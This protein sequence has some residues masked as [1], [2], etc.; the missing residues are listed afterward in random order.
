MV[1]PYAN[2]YH[3]MVVALHYSGNLDPLDV[4][5][6]Q[7]SAVFELRPRNTSLLIET[8]SQ[9]T[10]EV[11]HGQRGTNYII[12]LVPKKI[13]PDQFNTLRQAIELGGK[14]VTNGSGPP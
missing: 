2:D 14:W 8:D 12:L 13:K 5:D 1:K 4:S 3:V 9:F 11:Q 6:L 10:G 7:K